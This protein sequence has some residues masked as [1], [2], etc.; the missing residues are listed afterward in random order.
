MHGFAFQLTATAGDAKSR[1]LIFFYW[2]A[3]VITR[4]KSQIPSKT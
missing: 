3:P 1:Q 2:V 4:M